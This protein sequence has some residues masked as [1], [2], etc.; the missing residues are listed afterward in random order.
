MKDWSW[1]AFHQH[2]AI[3]QIDDDYHKRSTFHHLSLLFKN[4]VLLF[5]ESRKV[6]T[7]SQL[8]RFLLSKLMRNPLIQIFDFTKFGKL[9]NSVCLIALPCSLQFDWSH[10]KIVL[11]VRYFEWLVLRVHVVQF[12]DSYRRTGIF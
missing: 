3:V 9:I 1:H 10:T 4:R 11:A 6:Q 7:S 5:W 8:F 12:P 2:L